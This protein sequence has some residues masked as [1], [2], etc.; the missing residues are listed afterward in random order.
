MTEDR[1]AAIRARLEAAT[2][3]P[4]VHDEEG[5]MGCGEV[6]TMGEGVEG[7]NIAA[8]SGDCYP[9]S[10]YSP[11]EDMEFIAHAPDDIAYLLGELDKARAGVVTDEGLNNLAREAWDEG[12]YASENTPNPYRTKEDQWPA[13]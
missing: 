7:G 1:I 3:G 12:Y 10:G 6:Y 5:Y 8:P 11:K 13:S 9:R 4:W 2:P